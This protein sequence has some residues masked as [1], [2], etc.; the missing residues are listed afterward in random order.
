MKK[1]ATFRLSEDALRLLKKVA[2]P[3]GLSQAS[4]LEM[5]I[6]SAAKEKGIK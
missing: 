3:Q 6:R 2:K 4:V 5:A 1:S